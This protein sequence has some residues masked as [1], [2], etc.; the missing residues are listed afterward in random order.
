[1]TTERFELLDRIGHG[2]MGTVWKARDGESGGVVALKILHEHLSLDPYFVER[3]EREVEVTRR[4]DSPYVA[5]TLGFGRRE[6]RPFIVMEFVEGKSLRDLLRGQGPMSWETAS[7]ILRQIALGLD[8]AH[9]ANVIHR[10]VKPSNVLLTPDGTAKLVDFGIARAEDMTALT[11]T[12][13]TMGTPGYTTP[14]GVPG[15]SAD[16]YALGC[17]A[18]ELCTGNRAFTGDTTTEVAVRQ[19]RGQYDIETMPAEGRPFVQ[20]LLAPEER[21]RP[22][23]A[24]LVA[25]VLEGSSL[26]PRQR[27][28]RPRGP[29][30][31][32]IAGSLALAIGAI[33]ITAGIMLARSSV[34]TAA[35]VAP[36][37]GVVRTPSEGSTGGQYSVTLFVRYG[38]LLEIEFTV[39]AVCAEGIAGLGWNADVGSTKV[40]IGLEDGTAVVISGGSGVATRAEVIPC[41]ETRVG[42]WSFT[43]PYDASPP[44]AL[45]YPQPAFTVL[46]PEPSL[47]SLAGENISEERPIPLHSGECLAFRPAPALAAPSTQ[48][49]SSQF[50]ELLQAGMPSF[51]SSREWRLVNSPFDGW[52]EGIY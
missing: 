36:G 6:G 51:D 31:A 38:S 22:A 17:V 26:P 10:D 13:T 39:K 48:W 42:S 5:K 4:I 37:P 32:G 33:G 46:L 24:G 1:M 41:G 45:I 49:C 18:Y 34:E 9:K 23:D 47:W 44:R 35:T 28:R 52:V 43:M 3:F 50:P 8:A 19:M 15:K 30:I 29:I 7:P 20:W 2:G 16:L 11:G 25:S 12:S 40:L 21:L 14:D 27:G